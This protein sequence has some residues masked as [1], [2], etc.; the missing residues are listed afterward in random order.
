MAITGQ[1]NLTNIKREIINY[2][3]VNLT[4]PKSRGTT[5]LATLSGTG[6]ATDFLVNVS[7]IKG[8]IN[9]EHPVN[10]ALTYGTDYTY[11]TDY[12]DSGTK[13][14][15]ISFTAAPA[16]GTD[17]I[18]VNYTYGST[19]IYPD[20]SQVQSTLS[21]FPRVTVD[22][23]LASTN[24]DSLDGAHKLTNI[25]I[26]ITVNDFKPERLDSIIDEIRGLMLNKQKTF[27]Y[28]KY[29]TPSNI[30]PLIYTENTNNKIFQ[31]TIDFDSLFN[32]EVVS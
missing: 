9:V 14:L 20:Y 16:S 30:S 15:K 22:V 8:I 12:D 28:S 4:D 5:T 2:L 27:Y 21:D 17:N 1:I 24:D 11:D 18:E 32:F 23:L 7:T 13:K 10:T 31:R 29:I 25:T 26:S 6:V 3:R 19:W